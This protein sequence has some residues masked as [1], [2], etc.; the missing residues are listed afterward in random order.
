MLHNFCFTSI[1]SEIYLFIYRADKTSQN[2]D[3]RFVHRITAT[4]KVLLLGAFTPKLKHIMQPFV[5]CLQPPLTRTNSKTP[6]YSTCHSI[7]AN[8]ANSCVVYR[9]P[10]ATAFHFFYGRLKTCEIFWCEK[11]LCVK[12]IGCCTCTQNATWTIYIQTFINFEDFFYLSFRK[13][14]IE[15]LKILNLVTLHTILRL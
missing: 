13:N 7:D 9:G 4:P 11:F 5:N 6:I 8:A 3:C 12:L 15:I 1:I 14:K 2:W 10:K